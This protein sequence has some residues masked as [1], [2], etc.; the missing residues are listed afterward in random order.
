MFF[1]E[2]LVCVVSSLGGTLTIF[3]SLEETLSQLKV[4]GKHYQFGGS[5]R[6]ICVLSH[7]F[8]DKKLMDSLLISIRWEE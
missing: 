5:L 1:L 8:F 2:V 7:L 6:G 4:W 3:D